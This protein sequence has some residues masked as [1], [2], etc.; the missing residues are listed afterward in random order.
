MIINIQTVQQA[1]QIFEFEKTDLL[2]IALTHPSRIYEVY[3]DRQQQNEQETNI[4]Q[5]WLF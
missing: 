3:M 5:F 2:E 1:I 4:Y